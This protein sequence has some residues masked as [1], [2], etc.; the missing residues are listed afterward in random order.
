[1]EAILVVSAEVK[2]RGKLKRVSTRG[3]TMPS[4]YISTFI[5]RYEYQFPAECGGA[6]YSYYEGEGFGALGYHHGEKV[7]LDVLAGGGPFSSPQ[8]WGPYDQVLHDNI[9]MHLMMGDGKKDG[10]GLLKASYAIGMTPVM[11]DEDFHEYS[12]SYTSNTMSSVNCVNG[13]DSKP[14]PVIRQAKADI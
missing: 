9:E 7:V 13:N 12:A 2:S 5:N 10:M 8:L 14:A 1:M 11:A 6:K 3:I 4:D